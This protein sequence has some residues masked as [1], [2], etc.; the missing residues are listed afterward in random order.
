MSGKYNTCDIVKFDYSEIWRK[1]DDEMHTDT[2]L[3]NDEVVELLNE[4]EQLKQEVGYYIT[5]LQRLKEQAE[6]ISQNKVMPNDR[7]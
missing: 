3:R 4:N 1:S 7:I 2:P 6:R 5:L